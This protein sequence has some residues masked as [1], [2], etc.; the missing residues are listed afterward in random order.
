[1][2]EE[3]LVPTLRLIPVRGVVRESLLPALDGGGGGRI[4]IVIRATDK[5]L[6]KELGRNH[7]TRIVD[8]SVSRK[9]CEITF[10]PKNSSS[11]ST[12]ALRVHKPPSEHNVYLEGTKLVSQNPVPLEDGMTIYLDENR[13]GYLVRL[14]DSISEE[15]ATVVTPRSNDSVTAEEGTQREEGNEND[16]NV[17]DVRKVAAKE[18]GE[19]VMCAVC[20]DIMV[21]AKLAVPCGHVFCGECADS[22]VTDRRRQQ[23][24]TT[25]PNCRNP[26]SSV[27]PLKTLDNL[28]WGMCLQ[29]TFSADDSKHY[30]ERM[31]KTPTEAEMN[32]IFN[33]AP[34]LLQASESRSCASKATSRK[35]NFA[36]GE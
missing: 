21:K 28:V 3:K 25:C 23:Q 14:E 12:A 1:M 22:L 18:M 29:G 17:M 7:S 11:A 36:V 5:N 4:D 27:T 32:A 30:L 13:Y 15:K 26:I 9:L 6:T 19:E 24:M 10:I 35:R 2:N 31:G 8:L 20:M 33:V 16:S 34:Q